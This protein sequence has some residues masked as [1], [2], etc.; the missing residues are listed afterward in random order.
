MA[1]TTDLPDLAALSSTALLRVMCD[2]TA[3][4]VSHLHSNLSASRRTHDL[5]HGGAS[6]AIMGSVASD[7]SFRRIRECVWPAVQHTALGRAPSNDGRRTVTDLGCHH[8]L[9]LDRTMMQPVRLH[10]MPG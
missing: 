3:V 2:R 10:W 4:K 5:R 8:P 9:A 1:A 7:A 6:M